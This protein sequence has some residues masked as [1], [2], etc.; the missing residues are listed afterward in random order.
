[1]EPGIGDPRQSAGEDKRTSVGCLVRVAS[2]VALCAVAPFAKDCGRGIARWAFRSS[3]RQQPP[4]TW[5]PE[6]QADF[7]SGIG[8]KELEQK[9]G[10]P[11]TTED[12][13][14]MRRCMEDGFM[15]AYPFGPRQALAVGEAAVR[16]AGSKIGMACGLEFQDRFMETWSER[17]TS[18]W[19]DQC[20]KMMGTKPAPEEKRRFCICLSKVAPRHYASPAKFTEVVLAEK[21]HRSRGDQRKIDAIFRTCIR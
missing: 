5:T 13:L 2:F 18:W 4:A 16:E 17:S 8:P 10:V 9:L 15:K 20:A 12:V 11:V 6:T 3:E 7:S 1:L 14:A 19:A 21:E